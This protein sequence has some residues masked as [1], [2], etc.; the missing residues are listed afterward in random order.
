MSA[1]KCPACGHQFAATLKATIP[2]EQRI[3]MSLTPNQSGMFEART[4]GQT[5]DGF[6]KTLQLI[7]KDMGT[8][9]SVFVESIKQHDD[10]E[11]AVGFLLLQNKAK[12]G[13]GRE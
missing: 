9:L 3:T 2:D 4:L 6:R 8:P 7:G 13:V 11:I 10:G 1:I 12:A 5:I